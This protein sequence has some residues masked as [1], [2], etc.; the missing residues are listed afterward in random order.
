MAIASFSLG[1]ESNNALEIVID[2]FSL[3]LHLTNFSSQDLTRH[4]S[5]LLSLSPAKLENMK[6]FKIINSAFNSLYSYLD[7]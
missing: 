5:V 2:F 6:M 4:E 1:L 7:Y 3:R